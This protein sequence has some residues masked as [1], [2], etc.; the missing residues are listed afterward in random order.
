MSE[1]IKLSASEWKIMTLLWENEP[2]TI[3]EIT[4][5]LK[6]ETGWGK[7]T[8]ITLLKRMENKNAVSYVRKG[9]AKNYSTLYKREDVGVEET[10]SFLKRVY[11]GSIGLMVNSLIQQKALSNEEISELYDILKK[12][13]EEN[14][15]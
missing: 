7:H 6:E 11:R 15:K 5:A 12:S 3:M 14:N 10:E 1:R 8:V 4:A 2:M 9:N 13:E